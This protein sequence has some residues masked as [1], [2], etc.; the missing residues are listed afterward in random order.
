M[1]TLLYFTLPLLLLASC[2][3][4][5]HFMSSPEID[6]VKKANEAYFKGEWDALRAM[7]SDTAKVWNNTWPY[8]EKPETADQLI[9]G[10]KNGTANLAEY[11]M[12]AH[13]VYEMVIT[14]EGDKWIHCW[15]LWEGKTK[16]GKSY[17]SPVHLVSIVKDNKI[18]VHFLLY[19]ALPGYLAAHPSDSTST[20]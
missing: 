15:L 20:Q 4:K 18:V 10:F 8:T 16:N 5:Q 1:K 17:S 6:L 13:P 14:D 12:G 2:Q 9:E 3:Q 19:N 7:Y 11:K